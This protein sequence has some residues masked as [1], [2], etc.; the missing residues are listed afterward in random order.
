MNVLR[1][2]GRSGWPGVAAIVQVLD[3][4]STLVDLRLAIYLDSKHQIFGKCV[5]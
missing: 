4:M 3:K 1:L 5:F 2:V